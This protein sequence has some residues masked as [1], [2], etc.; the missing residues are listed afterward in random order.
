LANKRSAMKAHRVGERRHARNRPVRSALRTYVKK[1]RVALQGGSTDETAALVA[2]ATRHLDEAASKGIIHKNQAARRKSRLMHQL[3]VAARTAA[4][5]AEAPVAPARTRARRTTTGGAA[6]GRTTAGGT[7]ARTTRARTSA[8]SAI[9]SPPAAPVR[10]TRRT[11]APKE[12][13]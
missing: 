2:E 8:T 12:P 10:R 9:E 3:A 11:A 1:A 6:A 7:G 5:A 13:T 4:T